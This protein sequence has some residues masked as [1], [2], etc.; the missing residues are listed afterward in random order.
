[1]TRSDLT[2]IIMG[3]AAGMV[4]FT[5]ARAPLQAALERAR[6]DHATY[7][8]SVAE[9]HKLQALAAA[10]ALQAEQ[11]HSAGL[12]LRLSQQLT[13]INRLKDQRHAQAIRST[14][15]RA[16]LS[17][18][19]VR[20]LN[21]P[22]TERAAAPADLPAAA[23][24]ADAAHAPGTAAPAAPAQSLTDTDVAAW[25]ADAQGRYATCAARLNTLLDW[26]ASRPNTAP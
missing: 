2:L 24:G 18:D 22:A 20:V 1:M 21:T 5:L 4:G 12:R 13:T 3:V 25:V 26:A 19:T 7:R 11:L 9:T 8:A 10:R 6:A 17:A 14:T 16:C 15:G 23:P